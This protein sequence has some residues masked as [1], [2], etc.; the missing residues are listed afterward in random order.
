MNIK[1][2][3]HPVAL[4]MAAAIVFNLLLV[5]LGGAALTEVELVAVALFVQTAFGL[6]A[7]RFTRSKASLKEEARPPGQSRGGG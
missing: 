2:Q 5:R 7:T 4:A 6:I 3:E 1:P